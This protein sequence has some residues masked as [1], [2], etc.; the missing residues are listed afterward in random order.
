MLALV[1]IPLGLSSKK[2]GKSGG[3]VLTI[4][5][6]FVY[7]VISLSEF[8]SPD[9][10]EFLRGSER[11][12]P[13]LCFW[14]WR[15]FCCCARKGVPSNSPRSALAWK[16]DAVG[17]RSEQLLRRRE[18]AFERASTRRRVFSASFPTLLDDYVLRDF[19]VYLGMILSTF[20]VLV[21]VFTLFELLGDILRNQVPPTVV[22]EYLLNVT[23]YLLYNVAP[24]VML[25]A[26]LVT[27]GLMQRSNEITAIKATGTSIYRIV[28]PVVVAAAVL[29]VGSILR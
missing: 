2:S 17:S 10:E 26:V 20:L 25:L 23:P 12:W 7:Y 15:C 13:I 11:G 14:L 28:T 29:A 6:V 18:N 5:L 4:L 9:K 21:I 27:F 24:L 8:R 3:F 19:F 22:A 16:Q 1:G